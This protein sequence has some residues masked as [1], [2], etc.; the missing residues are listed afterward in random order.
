VYYLLLI[1]LVL[2]VVGALPHWRWSSGWGTGYYPSG[3]AGLALLLLVILLATG[4]L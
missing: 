1:V 3:L 2:A 4:R